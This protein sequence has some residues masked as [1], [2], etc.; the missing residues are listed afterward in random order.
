MRVCACAPHEPRCYFHIFWIILLQSNRRAFRL[1]AE[2]CCHWIAE[3][4]INRRIL[5]LNLCIHFSVR[6]CCSAAAIASVNEISMH[7]GTFGGCFVYFSLA[8]LCSCHV[9]G[10]SIQTHTHRELP[11]Y[12]FLIS[13]RKQ[14]QIYIYSIISRVSHLHLLLHTAMA[15]TSSTSLWHI[16]STHFMQ[17]LMVRAR[18][19]VASTSNQCAAW[20]GDVFTMNIDFRCDNQTNCWVS[21][22]VWCWARTRSC[23]CVWISG[24]INSIEFNLHFVYS[25]DRTQIPRRINSKIKFLHLV[26][27]STTMN[28]RQLVILSP[29]FKR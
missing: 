7:T 14:K 8:S 27:T 13:K 24:R 11:L 6:C 1:C 29:Q 9:R 25:H 4:N 22:T 20:F 10:S 23:A 21:A 12:S 26:T 3:K 18:L 28:K 2:S 16:Y 5:N 19:C 15:R 17:R